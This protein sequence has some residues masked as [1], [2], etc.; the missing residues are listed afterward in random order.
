MMTLVNEERAAGNHR[1][2]F[3]A[4]NLPTGTY[5]YT[6]KASGYQETRRMVLVR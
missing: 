6:M 4:G 1:V 2:T 3:D 5:L